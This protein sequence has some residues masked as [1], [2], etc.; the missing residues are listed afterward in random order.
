MNKDKIQQI[1][2]QFIW[3]K[4]ENTKLNFVLWSEVSMLTV[5]CAS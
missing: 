4:K 1:Y 3:R 2:L 5:Q